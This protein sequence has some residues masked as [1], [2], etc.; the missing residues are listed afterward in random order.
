MDSPSIIEVHVIYG[1]FPLFVRMI[2]SDF[3]LSSNDS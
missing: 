1:E 3:K 2:D